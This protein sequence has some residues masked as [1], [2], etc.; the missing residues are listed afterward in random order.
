M[1]GSPGLPVVVAQPLPAPP[2]LR[3]HPAWL[4]LSRSAG[5]FHPPCTRAHFTH[6][7]G[8]LVGMDILSTKISFAQGY[9]RFLK[10]NA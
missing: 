1:P 6:R 3:P 7:A 5:V 9:L 4:E 2:G 10:E 8:E